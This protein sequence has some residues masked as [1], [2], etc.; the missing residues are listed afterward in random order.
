MPKFIRLILAFLCISISSLQASHIVGGDFSYRHIQGDTYELKMK[1]YRDCVSST[2]FPSSI[3]VGFYDKAT[4]AQ[5]KTI[6]V[7]RRLIYPIQYDISCIDPQL[8]CV[9]TGIYTLN[10]DMPK[11]VFNNTEGYYIEW[12][13]CCRN[14]IIKNIINP[15]TTPM[16]FY[17]E[18]PSPYPGGGSQQINNSPEFTRDPLSYLCLGEVFKYDFKIYDADGDEI[19]MR[20]GIPLAGGATGPG[21]G[22]PKAATG[23][24]PYDDVIWSAGYGTSN[25]MDGA[26]DLMVD[27]DSA[28]IFL[29]PTQIG[30]YVISVIADEYRNGIKIGE[31]RR[32]L[33]LE[34]IICPPRH[35]PNITVDLSQ[36]NNVVYATIGQETCFNITAT[37]LDAAE[38]LKFRIDTGG[39]FKILST[40]AASLDPPDVS[41]NSSITAKFCWTPECPLDTANGAFLDFIAYDNSCPYPQDDTVRVK[42]II[43]DAPNNAPTL[44]T[45]LNNNVLN[46]HRNENACFILQGS[47]LNASNEINIRTEVQNFDVFAAGATLSPDVLIG[48]SILT[49]EFCWTPDCNLVIDSPI[50]LTFYINDNACPKEAFDTLRITINVLPIL[51]EQPHLVA[52]GINVGANNT[53]NIVLDQLNCFSIY[54]DDPDEDILDLTFEQVNYD[55][56]SNGATWV[57]TLDN[58]NEKRNE[59]CWTPSCDDFSDRDSIYLDF[60]V[61]D[62]KCNNEKFDTLR[63]Y[64]KFAFPSNEIPAILKPDSSLY[65]VNAGYGKSIEV[66]G[67]DDN[68]EDLMILSARK[69]FSDDIP[70]RIVMNSVQGNSRVESTL[71]VYADCGLDGS[72]NYPVE[73][74]LLSNKY[75][76]SFDTVYKVVNFKVSPLLDI[77]K[78]LLPDVFSPNGDGIND[79]YKIYLASRTICPDEFEFI[80]YDRWGQKMLETT[81]P[82]FA[83]KA[84]GCTAGAYVYYMRLGTQKLTGIIALIK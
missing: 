10:F 34:V 63:M 36:A 8:R 1:M 51:N 30:V 21:P 4:N 67:E 52:E 72:V 43:N 20:L 68:D 60:I 17:M 33:Q 32:E 57:N 44:K 80:I 37:D 70:F 48:N 73:L 31:V 56:S 47:D 13:G 22:V 15:G 58:G 16:A 41:A 78:P 50:Y 62:N 66:S 12:E 24:A 46:I 75:C 14:N 7:P 18:L 59:F 27:D 45:N 35:K 53:V 28:T 55:F 39:L 40:G 83:W 6:S 82:E 26:P 49:T 77:G 38:L 79:E 69:L 71:E 64:F 54:A 5:V 9:Q 74:S 61:R 84:E 2:Q 76:N 23:P 25:Y 29:R 65:T 3:Q 11:S 19:R 42:F 81:D